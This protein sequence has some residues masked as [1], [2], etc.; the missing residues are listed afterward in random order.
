MRNR[1]H[2]LAI[3]A[4]LYAAAA[5]SAG[6]IYVREG[7][8]GG[9]TGTSW[10]DAYADLHDALD[11]AAPGDEIWVATGI[12]Q[13]STTSA[14]VSYT[15]PAGVRLYGGFAG[16]ETQLDQR[17]WIANRT[18]LS[19][20]VDNDD[21][22]NGFSWTRV[23]SNSGHIMNASSTNAATVIDGFIFTRGAIGSVGTPA[24]SHLMA[25]AGIYIVGAS[26]TIRNCEF[27]WNQAAFSAGA[28]LYVRDGSP[29]IE[30][31]T[32][33]H[34]TGHLS[35]GVGVYIGG[36]S[37][38]TIRDCDFLYN[39]ATSATPDASG[40]G[41]YHQGSQP[42]FM[43]RCRFIGNSV[44]PFYSI[45]SAPCYGGG[46]SVFLAP[47]TINN[48]EFIDNT[49]IYGGGMIAWGP[50]VVSNSLFT[51][52][53]ARSWPNEQEGHGGGFMANS[54]ASDT[55]RLVNCTVVN[56]RASKYAGVYGGW[57][58]TVSLEN[59]IVWDNIADNP[60]VIG[61]WHEDVGGG[62]DLWYSCV[63]RIF[64]PPEQGEDLLEPN[65]LVGCTEADPAFVN[66]AADDF[67]LTAASPCIDA[68]DSSLVSVG[69]DLD[70]NTRRWDDPATPDSGTGPAPIVDMGAY[71]FNAPPPTCPGDADGDL[72]INFNDLNL[73]LAHWQQLV[74]AGTSGDVTGNG[75]VDFEDLN[76]VLSAWGSDCI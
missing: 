32:F 64:G 73:V 66:A 41:M 24:N 43:E 20:D 52:N 56:N 50:T 69:T 62:L 35:N 61:Y 63:S 7:A 30:S 39:S 51:G 76:L 38:C 59:T 37:A 71:E 13:P 42:L 12:Y 48:C 18:T 46:L 17:D 28:G 49:A 60:D 11:S 14:D 45:S 53:R 70:G 34:N 57:N 68:A 23:G 25:G 1:S 5:A 21:T 75:K 74:P 8:L 47:A 40:G 26:P 27:S 58:A 6:T 3:F 44:L 55:M 16:T 2:S 10:A 36:N 19:G 67:R 65:Q 15:M 22:F 33:E 29:V 4:L 54:F 72:M 31:C 9:N